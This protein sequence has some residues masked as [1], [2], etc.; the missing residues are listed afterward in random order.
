MTTY[1]IVVQINFPDRDITKQPVVSSDCAEND[2]ISTAIDTIEWKIQSNVPETAS[3]GLRLTG[4]TFY[5]DAT[6]RATFIPSY[7]SAG[8]NGSDVWTWSI[9]FTGPVTE[10]TVLTYMLNFAD[11][12]FPSLGWDPTLTINM[13][14]ASEA[15]AG[16]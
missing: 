7:L 1:T 15:G 12:D 4:L 9:S 2:P 8:T 6:K 16:G 10:D 14:T 11:L 5:T 13:R 3:D